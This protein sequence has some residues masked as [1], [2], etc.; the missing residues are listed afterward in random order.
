[1]LLQPRL[2]RQI[3]L[4]PSPSDYESGD[5]Y[6]L[7]RKS[8]HEMLMEPY[9]DLVDRDSVLMTSVCVPFWDRGKFV[10]Q[11]DEGGTS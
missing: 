8:G 1:M 9:K 2:L 11:W 4:Q 3:R 10:A 7:P 5:F 6:W